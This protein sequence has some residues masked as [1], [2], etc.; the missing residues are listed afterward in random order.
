MV[1][2]WLPGRHA[3][4]PRTAR[5][6]LPAR[7][8]T[9]RGSSLLAV[10]TD[11][12]TVSDPGALRGLMADRLRQRRVLEDSRVEA[13]MRTVPR[14][15]FIPGVAP[16]RAY[17]GESVVTHRDGQGVAVS[18]AS[19]AA[20]VAV[21]LQQLGVRPGDRVLEIGA[22]TGYNAALLAELAGP[23]GAV[24]SIDIDATVAGEAAHR[25]ESAGY[26]T[27]HVACG[28]GDAGLA[29]A[30]PFDKIIVTA[31]AWDLPQAW[32]DQ[33]APGGLL[34]VPLRIRG[35]TRSVALRYRDGYWRSESMHECGFMPIR[36][37][38]AMA[39]RN[40]QLA[41]DSGVFLRTDE[42][43]EADPDA[44]GAA[45]DS[46]PAVTWTGVITR[47]VEDLDLWLSALDGFCRMVVTAQAIERGLVKPIYPWG[48]MAVFTADSFAYLLQRPAGTNADGKAL[49]ELG[50]CGYGPGGQVLTADI[51][52]RAAAW[53]RDRP[54]LKDLWAEIHPARAAGLPESLITVTKR[55]TVV[56]VRT[57]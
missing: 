19:E 32:R 13:A 56:L 12:V 48:S 44:L 38:G 35:L 36:G 26:G 1:P 14:H 24:T 15:L 46:P 2:G 5:A 50:A 7:C 34:V 31:G 6:R 42:G 4:L 54:A 27:V 10:S 30:A 33:L 49:I 17:S 57:A 22:G 29:G 21:M 23:A 16:E 9:W 25:L 39:E 45:L 52:G 3:G 40:T 11:A 18:S 53:S 20:I 28:D 55:D 37:A 51:A 41:G 47:A 8:V 43:L